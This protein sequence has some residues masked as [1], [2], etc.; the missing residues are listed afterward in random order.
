MNDLRYSIEDSRRFLK[1]AHT[2]DHHDSLEYDS[3]DGG[4]QMERQVSN[5]LRKT[6]TKEGNHMAISQFF[7]EK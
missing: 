4:Q 5:H 7:D 6:V 3:F 1:S 2:K